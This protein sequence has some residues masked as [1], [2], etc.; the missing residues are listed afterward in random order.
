MPTEFNRQTFAGAGVDRD[1]LRVVPSAID[2]ARFDPSVATYRIN[3]ARGYNFLSIFDWSLRKG[4]DVL[5]RAF[6]AEFAAEEDVA[7]LFKVH[8][9]LGVSLERIVRTVESFLIDTLGRDPSRIP[10]IVFQDTNVPDARM[11]SLYRGANCYVMPTRGEGW[12]RP[13]ME[14]MAM[15]LPTI[16]TNWSGQTEFMNSKNSLLLDCE[17][18]DVPEVGWREIPTY[19]GHKWA[20]PS[21]SHL[22]RLMRHVFEDRESGRLLGEQA[23][24]DIAEKYNY[25]AVSARIAEEVDRL[26]KPAATS[27]GLKVEA[28][29]Q[30]AEQ[31]KSS[32]CRAGAEDCIDMK[33]SLNTRHTDDERREA[34][35][36]GDLL[37]FTDRPA[38]TALCEHARGHIEAAFGPE[39]ETAQFRMAVAEF[40]A[41]AGP[42]KS[43]FT[44]DQ[45]TKELV[46]GVLAEFG[47]DLDETY[48]DVPRLRVVTSD[49]YLTAGVGYA[50]KAHRDTW[51]SSPACQV[52]WWSPV[53]A[54]SEERS[55]AFYPR[56]WDRP[57]T[58]S[59]ADFDYDDWLRVGRAQAASQVRADT[60]NHPLPKEPLDPADELRV[61]IGAAEMVLFSGA[62]LHATVPNS[63]D[64]TRFSFDFRTVN[65]LDLKAGA[66]AP[67]VDSRARGTTL[68]D[69]LRASDFAPIPAYL[70]ADPGRRAA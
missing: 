22:R 62:H 43:T 63:S 29:G 9:S 66:G 59:S 35:F 38:L 7:L 49:G 17:V 47:C 42:L 45:A 69:F 5:I 39:A 65:E 40:V 58:N 23:R 33:I 26:F 50:Y 70:V 25:T 30:A 36:S 46:R 11:P 24:Q 41:K 32:I 10:D 3:G 54:L 6:V 60:R 18:V 55:L 19:R 1:K 34:L 56:V 4:W 52:N 37:L 51:Y 67:N 44:N 61:T 12:G 53:F 14:A 21:E 64:R 28:G 13:F 31:P 27:G 8:S 16:G 20:E 68:G 15:G 57:V 48:F 2:I